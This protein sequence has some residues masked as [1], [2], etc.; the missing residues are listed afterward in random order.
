MVENESIEVVVKEP[1]ALA[2]LMLEI[3]EQW[4]ILRFLGFGLYYAWIWLCYDSAVLVAP[5]ALGDAASGTVF[6]MYLASTAA[7]SLTLILSAFFRG[8][9]SRVV[10]SG[11]A[12]LA[13]GALAGVSTFGVGTTSAM[14]A[15]SLP[16]LAFS[17]ATGIGTAWVAL[18]LGA[19]CATLP[20]RQITLTT[21]A[22]FIVA[23]AAYFIVV[24]LPRFV[25]LAVMSLLPLMAALSTM[26]TS[27]EPRI[28]VER[29]SV[30]KRLP[31]GFFPRLMSSITVFSLIVGV[32]RGFS[33]L[34]EGPS[35]L[36]SEGSIIVFGTAVAAGCLYVA[37]ALLGNDFD[38]SRLY[39]P[40]IFLLVLGITLMPVVADGSFE[41]RFV[42]IAYACFSMLMW[43]LFSH[44]S[45]MSG[46]SPVWVFGLGRGASAMGTTVGWL[47][48]SRLIGGEL[49]DTGI[50]ALVSVTMVVALL[51][52]SMLVFNDRTI[53]QVLRQTDQGAG[54]AER[55]GAQQ[56]PS[57][58]DADE[59]P[60]QAAS[61]G[62][63][64]P[65]PDDAGDRRRGLFAQRCLVVSQTYG[66]SARER[67]VLFL[68]AKGRTINYIAD[69][70]SVS[71]NTAKSHI[72]HVYVK[73]G[74]HTRQELIDMI[75]KVQLGA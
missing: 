3:D 46:L 13:M 64:S 69:D 75:E 18:R 47:L 15:G 40:I 51:F 74:V 11:T 70:L 67:D 21:A 73:T 7:L 68:L 58:P 63:A 6:A 19:I 62:E 44:V 56:T 42:G 50:S 33:T 39:Y 34:T 30:A 57:A 23:C 54:P 24:G 22:S 41:G 17:I 45:H 16:F 29:P 43:C 72:R 10:E 12:V 8:V 31:R 71:F 32:T 5:A 35:V 9:S 59:K 60:P 38:I 55:D 26:T 25:G 36:A 20:A 49:Q 53:G 61:Q 27:E 2:R 37:V 28:Q 52:I 14:G 48:G 66:L 4:P 1:S 65:A